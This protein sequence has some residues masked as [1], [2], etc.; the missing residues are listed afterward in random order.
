MLHQGRDSGEKS[1]GEVPTQLDSARPRNKSQDGRA[2]TLGG[3][4]TKPGTREEDVQVSVTKTQYTVDIFQ[5]WLLVAPLHACLS[6][7]EHG[8]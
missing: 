7:F 2:E 6:L 1:R 4:K 8:I 3:N 5:T